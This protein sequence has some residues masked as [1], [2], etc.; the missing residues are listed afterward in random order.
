M[1]AEERA[2]IIAIASRQNRYKEAVAFRKFVAAQIEEAC[3]EE[4]ARGSLDQ[5]KRCKEH[6]LNAWNAARDKAAMLAE[7]HFGVKDWA[8]AQA[9]KAMQPDE[10]E[11]E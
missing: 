8:G 1:K 7:N 3:A 10:K 2:E 9:I 6:A 11:G 5:Q 4:F